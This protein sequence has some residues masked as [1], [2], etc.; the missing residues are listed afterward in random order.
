M[1]W[2]NLDRDGTRGELRD[3]PVRSGIG[4]S[5]NPVKQP[6][7]TVDRTGHS[8]HGRGGQCRE[9]TGPGPGDEQTSC[10]GASPAVWLSAT[11]EALISVRLRIQGRPRATIKAQ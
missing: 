10:S 7:R 8:R 2:L 6:G 4:R 3:C 5:V 11:T 9:H 1:G